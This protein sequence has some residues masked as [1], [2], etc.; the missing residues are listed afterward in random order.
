MA[1]RGGGLLGERSG[2]SA[3]HLRIFLFA[4]LLSVLN[5]FLRAPSGRYLL[6]PVVDIL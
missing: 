2:L 4:A 5:H 3:A 1:W 6:L